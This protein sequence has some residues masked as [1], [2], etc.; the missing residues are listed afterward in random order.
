MFFRRD[1]APALLEG[2][3]QDKD[4]LP[5]DA[6]GASPDTLASQPESQVWAPQRNRI[7]RALERA[8]LAVETPVNRLIGAQT[9][10]PFYHT[11]TI[12]VWL[13]IIVA[14]TGFYLTFFMQFGFE[15]TF[16]AIARMEAHPLAHVIRAMHRYASVFALVVSL[17]HGYRL[18]F[19]DRFRGPRWL[20]WVTGVLMMVVLW[21]DGVIGYWLVWDERSQLITASFT[22]WLDTLTPWGPSFQG[23]IL[24]AERLDRGWILI[25]LLL[26]VHILL[27]VLVAVMFWLH[28]V[29]LSRPKFLPGRVWL[30]GVF[31]IVLVL[32]IVIPVGMLA[33]A[34][35]RALPPPIRVDP[36]Y[37]FF[38]PP[39]INADAWWLWTGLGV[40]L[41][42]SVALPWLPRR[43]KGPPPI[44]IDKDLCTGCTECAMDCPYKAIT[45]VER[46]DGKPHKYIAIE[47][48][49]MCV[50]CGVCLGS[51][52]LM[53]VS[54]SVLAPQAIPN[55][56]RT[57]LERAKRRAPDTPITVVYTCE[58]HALFGADRD[59]ADAAPVAGDGPRAVE[60]IA[61]P[62]VATASP[63][64]VSDTLE[65][66]AAD[67]RVVGCPP[68]DCSRRE[69]NLWTEG[70]LSRQ[71]VPR[72]RRAYANAP[73]T[74]F[75]LAPDRFADA[76]PPPPARVGSGDVPPSLP[77]RMAPRLTV[78]NI[79]AALG[80]VAAAFLALVA[81]SAIPMPTFGANEARLAVVLPNPAAFFGAAPRLPGGAAPTWP[82]RLSV[83]VDG[84]TVLQEALA[85]A[86]VY[87]GRA[88]AVMEEWP[89][90]P[91]A[92]RIQ[93][94]FDG[95]EGGTT[96]WRLADRTV[97]LQ[98][99]E[100]LVLDDFALQGQG[101]GR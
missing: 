97:T 101:G 20:A 70:R 66:G 98:P 46:H 17:L 10:N 39:E 44:A 16:A 1:K 78:R 18:L 84:Q 14:V 86:D 57:R 51:C 63:N 65:M 45:M 91:G 87:A 71:R 11:G 73:I 100:A 30:A 53:A 55:A 15:S 19:M 4:C 92:H 82:T 64:L 12:A 52:D 26:L 83:A 13:W 90:T 77:G 29:R 79:A 24:S 61:L 22:N 36:F 41:G 8:A 88:P 60:V 37:L 96:T 6:G 2:V 80:L 75:W 81:L 9:L 31:A 49:A 67:V 54:L 59:L 94:W 74:T 32:A 33:R 35:F 85:P 68:D 28:I 34:D 62:C 99:R 50:A 5:P 48:P 7:L 47:D 38:L 95:G 40:L 42:L 27:F 72:L 89:L 93:V 21:V 56:T 43:H 76:L 23:F 25:G 69:G 3:D 58:R